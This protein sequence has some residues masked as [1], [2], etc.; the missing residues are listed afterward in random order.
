[1]TLE[2]SGAQIKLNAMPLSSR[3]AEQGALGVGLS[4]R[5]GRPPLAKL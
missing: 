3:P 1:L 5:A 4:T 2:R